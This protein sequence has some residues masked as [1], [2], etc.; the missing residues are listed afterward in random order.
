MPREM[1]RRAFLIR[2]GAFASAAS[3]T[4]ALNSL[5]AEKNQRTND[6]ALEA[7]RN[8]QSPEVLAKSMAEQ[9]TRRRPRSKRRKRR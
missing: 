9:Q 5:A 1:S 6:P 2:T 7:L 3:H 4:A 8:R